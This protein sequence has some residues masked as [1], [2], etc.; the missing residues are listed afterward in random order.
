MTNRKSHQTGVTQTY[1]IGVTH[2][3]PT[4]VSHT[5]FDATSVYK[6]AKKK[7]FEKR[8]PTVRGSDIAHQSKRTMPKPTHLYIKALH[9]QRANKGFPEEFVQR[10]TKKG[11]PD[12][13]HAFPDEGM[14][15][16]RYSLNFSTLPPWGGSST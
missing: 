7:A 11:M 14:L 12:V 9:G 8:S 6:L 3:Y 10:Q 5:D 2:S 4:G 1:P 13:G 16:C 15:L